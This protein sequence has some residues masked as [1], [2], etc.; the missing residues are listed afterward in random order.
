MILNYTIVLPTVLLLIQLL[1]CKT[2]VSS[3]GLEPDCKN[4][5]T[6]YDSFVCV[7]TESEPCAKI[8]TPVRTAPDVVN[9]WFS[10]RDGARL[11]K[12]TL[13]FGEK[14]DSTTGNGAQL[15]V[16]VNREIKYQEILGF[17]GAFTDATGINLKALGDKL[18]DQVLYDYFSKD[19]IE[20]SVNRVPIGGSDFSARGY[21]YDNNV[22]DK[23]LA[24]WKLEREDY[25]YKI[26]YIKRAK[27]LATHE[28]RLFGS[29]WSAP[30]WMKTNNDI[31]HGGTIKGD[32][33]TEYWQIYA[34]YLV[35]YLD[36]YKNKHNI[37]HWG[38]TVLNEPVITIRYNSMHINSTQMRD[39]MAKTLGPELER[40]GWATGVDRG[41][42]VMT[43]D[44]NLD[45][46]DDYTS[47]VYADT[48]A[49]KYIAGTA[50]HWYE[51]KTYEPLDRH[52]S[53]RSDKFLLS[54]E[55][56]IRGGVK[57]G[58]WNSAEQYAYD[59][60]SVLLHYSIGW[61][62]WNMVL[63]TQGGP[64]W[65]QNYVDA[66]I[67]A[68][69]DKHEYYRQPHFY[70]LA[71]FSKFIKPGSVRVDTQVVKQEANNAL[72]GAF[73]TPNNSTVVT[74]VNNGDTDIVFT[75]EDSKAGKLLNTI[76]KKSIQTYVYYD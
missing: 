33:G 42:R 50:F 69:P 20:Y 40:S 39:F 4:H 30:K 53:K 17:G 55:A 41:F 3:A 76:T 70:A 26:P 18:G 22:E 15:H 38:L 23:T 61:V 67:L 66:P 25:D 8:E 19:G 27:E 21:E 65:V 75:L 73:R 13:K 43:W 14:L 31:A 44:W 46:I 49:A 16:K 2:V 36:E 35:K 59:I 68:N 32:V 12:Q 48:G 7:C 71:Q 11:R 24:N 9:N 58:L 28:I 54:T 6:G 45:S 72:V 52:Y 5:K 37:T 62:D 60:L 47:T 63:D 57:I 56:C 29:P 10:S 64:N 34:K 74:V 1:N 51:T